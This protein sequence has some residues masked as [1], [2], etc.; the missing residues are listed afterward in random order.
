MT[1]R[2]EFAA[3]LA[4]PE[5]ARLEFKSARGSFHFEE[6]VRYEDGPTG[7]EL[8]G[9]GSRRMARQCVI[10]ARHSSVDSCAG[11]GPE[12]TDTRGN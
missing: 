1:S 8:R 7:R 6:L 10:P 9:S 3:L 4:A 2:Q 12:V 11:V 5:G